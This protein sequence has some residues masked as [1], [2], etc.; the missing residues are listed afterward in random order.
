MK[1]VFPF[2]SIITQRTE[3]EPSSSKPNEPPP[4]RV[5]NFGR[6][7]ITPKSPGLTVRKPVGFET[8]KSLSTGPSMLLKAN[9]KV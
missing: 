2:F 7:S 4:K 6:I 1:V 9:Y 8:G 5:S 3:I